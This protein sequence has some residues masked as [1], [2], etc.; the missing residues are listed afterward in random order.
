MW[1][2]INKS[3]TVKDLRNALFTVSCKLQELESAMKM[4]KSGSRI[5]YW[6]IWSVPY[7]V[8]TTHKSLPAA[9][10]AAREC[11]SRGGAIHDI[12]KVEF[13]PRRST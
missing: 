6:T 10:R 9:K 12:I 8:C 11:E 7:Q 4:T 13:I 2:K 5:E 3:K 1:A